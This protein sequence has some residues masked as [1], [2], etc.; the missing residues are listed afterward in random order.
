VG[1]GSARCPASV[2]AVPANGLRVAG[3]IA[4]SLAPYFGSGAGSAGITTKCSV[5]GLDRRA[6]RRSC[7]VT[8]AL[9]FLH[10]SDRTVHEQAVFG[11]PAGV[12]RS[13]VDVDEDGAE[14]RRS[15]AV[16][17]REIASATAALRAWASRGDPG[18][19]VG[20]N[21]TRYLVADVAIGLV[22]GVSVPLCATALPENRRRPAAKPRGASCSSARARWIA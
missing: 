7:W 22:G 2:A 1:T 15:A 11:W 12:S 4:R 16:L 6:Y 18:T 20:S 3:R 14:T 8:R 17:R 9:T 13:F 19:I 10:R 5:N 21:S